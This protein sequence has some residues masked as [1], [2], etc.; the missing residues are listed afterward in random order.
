MS[1]LRS[2]IILTIILSICLINFIPVQALESKSVSN[3]TELK[4]A[5]ANENIEVIVLANDIETTEKINITRP[6]IID[7]NNKTI[8]YVGTFG[9]SQSKDNTIWAGIY[10]L[11]VYKTTA[12]IKNIKLTGANAALLV[13]GS[14]VKLE[15]TIDVSGNGFGGIELGKG[16]DVTTS[17]HLSLDSINQIINTTETENAPTLWTPID[18]EGAILEVAGVKYTLKANEEFSLLELNKYFSQE[19]NPETS[20]SFPKTSFLFLFSSIILLGIGLKLKETS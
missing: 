12:T 1:K 18:T 20:V 5:L 7:G 3:Q 4:E 9:S 13:N 6:V 10:V 14:N 2:K 15:G 11:Q 19:E 8:R 17:P 16:K